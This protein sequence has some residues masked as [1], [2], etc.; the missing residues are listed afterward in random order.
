MFERT[1]RI[2]FR[3]SSL[4]SKVKPELDLTPAPAPQ[5]CS[6]YC[7]SRLH[8]SH[9]LADSGAELSIY[10]FN[11]FSALL[12]GEENFQNLNNINVQLS[13]KEKKYM[14]LPYRYLTERFNLSFYPTC[15]GY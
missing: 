15:P 4:L 6:R 5:H 12:L 14:V 1:D 11:L 2:S 10:S 9:I 8:S 7:R 13:E 3:I